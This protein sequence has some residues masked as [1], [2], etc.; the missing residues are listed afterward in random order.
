M[1]QTKH[2]NHKLVGFEATIR[3]PLFRKQKR[4]QKVPTMKLLPLSFDFGIGN[5]LTLP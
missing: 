2:E 5:Y 1:T 3:D 4:F